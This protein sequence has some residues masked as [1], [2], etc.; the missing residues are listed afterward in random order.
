MKIPIYVGYISETDCILTDRYWIY[1][2]KGKTVKRENLN[3]SI[4]LII[5]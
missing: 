5:Y 4:M 1:F 3:Y 2:L